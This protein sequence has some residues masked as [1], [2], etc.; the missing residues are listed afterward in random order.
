[1]GETVISEMAVSHLWTRDYCLTI[2]SI[3][4][5]LV[6]PL[7][8]SSS[9]ELHLSGICEL[10]TATN[11]SVCPSSLSAYIFKN[12]GYRSVLLTVRTRIP[13]DILEKDITISIVPIHFSA[14][15]S[16]FHDTSAAYRISLTVPIIFLRNFIL[17]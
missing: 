16:S 3:S 12:P 14:D 10:F 8:Y 9:A 11:S 13:S 2:S 5:R 1:M 15:K 17:Q 7:K 6:L 4:K